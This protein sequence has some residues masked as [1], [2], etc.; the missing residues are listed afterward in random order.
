MLLGTILLEVL[1]PGALFTFFYIWVFALFLRRRLPKSSNHL[2]G[3]LP[4]LEKY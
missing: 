1:E 3:F 2:Q 4:K